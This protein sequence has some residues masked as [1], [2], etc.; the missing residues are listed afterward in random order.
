MN[1]LT[2]QPPAFFYKGHERPEKSSPEVRAGWVHMRFGFVWCLCC[3]INQLVREFSVYT[4]SSWEKGSMKARYPEHGGAAGKR[5]THTH[6]HTHTRL[7]DAWTLGVA[8][9]E[10]EAE[11]FPPEIKIEIVPPRTCTAKLFLGTSCMFFILS[12]RL[13]LSRGEAWVSLLDGFNDQG[14]GS[15]FPQPEHM[16]RI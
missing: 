16:R 15:E 1:L 14:K 9:Q 5:N 4:H 2:P 7:T 8:L 3:P 13:S 11:T 6:T 12:P 10:C